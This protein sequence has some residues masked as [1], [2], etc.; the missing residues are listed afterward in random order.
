[1]TTFPGRAATAAAMRNSATPVRG[2]T[3]RQP[4]ASAICYLEKLIENR[5]HPTNY[6]GLVLIH[7][8]KHADEKALREVSRDTERL[9]ERGVVL[10][11]AQLTGAHTELV[12]RGRC[13]TWAQAGR[14]HWQLSGVVT[15][16]RPV[17]AR[18]ALYLWQPD[19]TLREAVA[20][21]LGE[22]CGERV[23]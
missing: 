9:N 15:L 8:A 1:M 10:G 12:C 11:V 4:Y 18:G 17:P 23:R 22:H 6:R 3:V 13:S 14:A 2:L 20:D 19:T 7:A 21:A 16:Y 5:R